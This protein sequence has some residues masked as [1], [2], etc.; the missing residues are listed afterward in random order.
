MSGKR[1]L[2]KTTPPSLLC[3]RSRLQPGVI[4][5]PIH[6]V[7]VT[8]TAGEPCRPLKTSPRGEVGCEVTGASILQSALGLMVE[9]RD[10]AIITLL[11]RLNPLLVLSEIKP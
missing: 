7:R 4:C 1:A 8:R 5:M 9:E 10:G 2:D 11:G 6:L 3:Y